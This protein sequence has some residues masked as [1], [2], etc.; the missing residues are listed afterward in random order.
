MFRYAPATQ[1]PTAPWYRRRLR[2]ARWLLL[3]WCSLSALATASEPVPSYRLLT[4]EATVAGA[5]AGTATIAIARSAHSYRIAGQARATGLLDTLSPWR[6]NFWATGS[7]IDG[8]PVPAEYRYVERGRDKRRD[9]TV[10]D[11]TL[12]V[13]KNGKERPR[14]PALPGPDVLAALFLN[15]ECSA[16]LVLHT[17]RHGYHLGPRPA[18]EGLPAGVPA[19]PGAMVAATGSSCRYRVTDDDQDSFDAQLHFAEVDALRLP[20]EITISGGL[21]GSLVLTKSKRLPLACDSD[22]AALATHLCSAFP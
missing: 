22:A 19:G 13:I 3:A 14:R 12:T 18:V 7:V 20:I 9:V 5:P 2:T 11:G 1:W 17:G 21:R 6:A 16:E 8:Q 15:S 10:R 4:F